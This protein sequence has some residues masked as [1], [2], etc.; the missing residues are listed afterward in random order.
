MVV[1]LSLVVL[2]EDVLP[3]FKNPD[4]LFAPAK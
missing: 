3:L 4:S 1:E 2:S